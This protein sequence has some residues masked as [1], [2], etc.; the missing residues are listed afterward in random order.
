MNDA[1]Y[2]EMI[3]PIIPADAKLLGSCRWRDH[4]IPDFPITVF[5]GEQDPIFSPEDAQDWSAGTTGKVSI[6][7]LPGKHMYLLQRQSLLLR[8]ISEIIENEL[9]VRRQLQAR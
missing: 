3:G 7:S 9:P 4:K 5:R 2:M 1:A 8:H 6:R